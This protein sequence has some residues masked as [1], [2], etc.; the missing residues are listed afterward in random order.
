[1]DDI[2]D[3]FDV[4]LDAAR[5]AIVQH[6]IRKKREQI[7]SVLKRECGNC[8]KWMTSGCVPEKAHKQFKSMSSYAC[9]DF[10]LCPDSVRLQEQFT[11]ELA[12]IVDE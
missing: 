9:G 4:F 10:E 8:A 6:K 11:Q 12:E 5:P 1:M 7:L 2:R 3:L